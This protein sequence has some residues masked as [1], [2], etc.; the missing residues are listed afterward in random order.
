MAVISFESGMSRI[1]QLFVSSFLFTQITDLICALSCNLF[2]GYT[3][4][5][6]A[7][8]LIALKAI[9]CGS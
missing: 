9:V 7:G 1:V 3:G 4:L 8:D 2:F 6:F 5:K